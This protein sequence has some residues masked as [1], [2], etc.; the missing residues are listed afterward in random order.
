MAY[1]KYWKYL[2]WD[3]GDQRNVTRHQMNQVV[4]TKLPLFEN[5]NKMNPKGK[6]R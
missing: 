5:I 2:G 3:S 4:D 1:I 6:G